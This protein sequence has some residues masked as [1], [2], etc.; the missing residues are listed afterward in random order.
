MNFPLADSL[1]FILFAVIVP[2]II[3]RLSPPVMD[4]GD[5]LLCENLPRQHTIVALSLKVRVKQA[6]LASDK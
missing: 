5:C 4:D 2:E 6:F 3:R 1:H